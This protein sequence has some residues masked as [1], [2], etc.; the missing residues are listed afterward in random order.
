M[1]LK[2]VHGTNTTVNHPWELTSLDVEHLRSNPLNLRAELAVG[3]ELV[4]SVRAHGVLQPLIVTETAFDEYLIIAGHRRFAAAVR[5]GL[6]EVPAVIRDDLGETSEQVATMLGENADRVGLNVVEKAKGYQLMLDDGMSVTVISKRTGH[7]PAAIKKHLPA[8]SADERVQGLLTDGKISLDDLAALDEFDDDP[9]LRERLEQGLGTPGWRYELQRHQHNRRFAEQS[10]TQRDELE[11]KGIPVS[12]NSMAPDDPGDGMTWEKL[13]AGTDPAAAAKEDGELAAIVRRNYNNAKDPVEVCLYKKVPASE[14]AI[15]QSEEDKAARLLAEEMAA[16]TAVRAQWLAARAAR[17]TSVTQAATL[18]RQ[19]IM[20]KLADAPYEWDRIAALLGV[21]V[22]PP[23]DS[24]HTDRIE[25]ARTK[26][27]AALSKMLLP[28]LV[29]HLFV[30]ENDR[31]DQELEHESAWGPEDK[32]G[33]NGADILAWREQLA[34]WRYP[35][36]PVEQRL[37]D[38]AAAEPREE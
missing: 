7:K 35:L 25:L 24:N 20:N 1:T 2:I 9:E 17:A 36:A 33:W 30:L 16:A 28:Q 6:S 3:A 4:E 31:I 19:L 38:A 29:T 11:S 14:K 21:A 8:A 32:L 5:A 22:D 23:A 10:V 26:I 18:A 34:A 12:D 13:P 15:A 37:V 27:Q